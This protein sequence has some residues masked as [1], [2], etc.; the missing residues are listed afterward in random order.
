MSDLLQFVIVAGFGALCFGCGYLIAF[1]V[2]R[3]RWRDEMIRRG[4][5]RYDWRTG[6][7]DWGEPP[8]EGQSRY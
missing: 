5:V 8:K 6:K 7:W 2:T 1:T 3:N 4:V